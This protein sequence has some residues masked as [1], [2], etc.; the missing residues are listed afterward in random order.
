MTMATTSPISISPTSRSTRTAS[1]QS[2]ET[3]DRVEIG[4]VPEPGA[5]PPTQVSNRNDY[6]REAARSD[7]RVF[8]IFFDDYHVRPETAQ[9]AA[10]Q[11]TEFL[12]NNLQPA[13]LVAVMYPLTPVSEL[14]FHAQPSFGDLAGRG[15]LRAQ[16]RL[17]APEHIRAAVLELSD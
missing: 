17:R 2:F 4:A 13:D 11:M 7:V 12:Q 15:L 5:R 3:F 9:R 1:S 14:R 10:R 6:E 8:V 16:V